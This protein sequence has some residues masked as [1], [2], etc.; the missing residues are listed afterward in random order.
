MHTYAHSLMYI[1]HH[2]H[3]HPYTNT[4]TRYN[5]V[6]IFHPLAVLYAYMGRTELALRCLLIVTQTINNPP[7]EAQYLLADA[8]ERGL[9]VP[10][11]PSL[12]SSLPSA[13]PSAAAAAPSSIAAAA[14]ND[15]ARATLV[16]QL[17]LSIINH[18]SYQYHYDMPYTGL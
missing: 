8:Y 3:V 15:E 6:W 14:G 7:L 12:P 4:G 9:L 18:N 2:T 5:D 10:S 1:Y 13:S 11:S 16:S 17:Y